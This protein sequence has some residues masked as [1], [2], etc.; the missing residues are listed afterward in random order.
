[1][2]GKYTIG[3]LARLAG[4]NIQTIHYYER[5]GLIKPAGRTGAGYRLYD[6]RILK[7]LRF[8]RRAK[9]LGFMLK[10]INGLLDLRVESSSDCDMAKRKVEAKLKAVEQRIEALD[11]V[12]KIL[13]ELMDACDK[14]Q[15]TDDCPILK[16]IEEPDVVATSVGEEKK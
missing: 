4:V 1:M 9:G 2:L 12:R 15:P 10:E 13:N 6:D 11:S 7:R 8:I 3:E 14:R 16:A 5:R